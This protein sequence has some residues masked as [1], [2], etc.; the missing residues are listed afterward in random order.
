M[1]AELV[2]LVSRVTR[3]LPG[4][5]EA[6]E[7]C[8]RAGFEVFEAIGTGTTLHDL[9]DEV[10][11]RLVGVMVSNEPCDREA[12]ERMPRLRA[13]SC[14]G[15]GQDHVDLEET[16]RRGI[17]VT[18]GRGGN[19]DAVAEHALAMLFALARGLR[20][21]QERLLAGE[22]WNPWPPLVPRDVGGLTVGIVGFGAIGQALGRRVAA[23]GCRVLF[24]DPSVD[25]AP[26]GVAAARLELGELLAEADVVSLHV[27]LADDTRGL[28]GAAELARMRPDAILL[29]LSRG[30]VVDERAALDA[31]DGGRLGGLGLD[32]FEREGRGAP[33]PPSHPRLIG[34]P[35]M[36]GVSDRVARETRVAAAERLID[37]L[38]RTEGD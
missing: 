33:P 24:T 12:L 11:G 7:I 25:E 17:A 16:A 19:A 32:V 13:L 21:A 28:I 1:A 9:P 10:A 23:L 31:L 14:I 4:W 34:T 37:A 26:D 2:A 6:V 5:D 38:R 15:S 36:G 22:G 27:P 35:H 20:L 18:S 3:D 30:G 29:N 8:E